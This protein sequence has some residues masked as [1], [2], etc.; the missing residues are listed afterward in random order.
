[1]RTERSKRPREHSSRISSTGWGWIITVL[2]SS[3]LFSISVPVLSYDYRVHIV[4]AFVLAFLQSG[5]LPLAMRQPR[6]AIAASST[7]AL[8]LGLVTQQSA[9]PP[10]PLPVAAML[11]QL[12]I[13]ALVSLRY[14]WSTA[15]TAWLAGVLATVLAVLA[16]FGHS[17]ALAGAINNCVTFASLA[18]AILIVGVLIKQRQVIRSQLLVERRISAEE[19]ARR[20]LIEEKNRVAR[21]LHDV[22]AHNMSVISVQASTAQYRLPGLDVDV[23][24]EF[25]EIAASSRQAMAEMRSL[26]TV[27]RATDEDSTD[28]ELR[29]APTLRQLPELISAAQRGGITV[30][31]VAAGAP[32]E[33]AVSHTV[34]TAGYRIIQE[35]LSNVIRHA[36]G[37]NTRISV[38][39]DQ[40]S[41]RLE[42]RNAA[43]PVPS[44]DRPE[45]RSTAEAGSGHGIRGM[46]ERSKL[47][48]GTVNTE[49]LPDGGFIVS[50]AL[51]LA[52][53]PSAG[54]PQSIPIRKT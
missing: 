13:I 16:G 54:E 22:V 42:V 29:P 36:P 30:E 40:A 34:G 31:L 48:G 50:A 12:A 37:A 43:P 47:V 8:A 3:T 32:E 25:D 41:L 52:P 6:I 4:P 9:G 23:R 35:A 5:A 17:A 26:L 53:E 10:W 1:M 45:G 20:T 51:P 18:G 44:P 7:A 38:A 49:H 19:H 15:V 11:T 39:A 14:H 33:F 24:R 46:H 28:P 2:L 21:E 27:L